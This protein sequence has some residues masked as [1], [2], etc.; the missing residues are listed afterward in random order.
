[1]AGPLDNVSDM[2]DLALQ[3]DVT[4]SAKRFIEAWKPARIIRDTGGARGNGG[5]PPSLPILPT[6]SSPQNSFF[7]F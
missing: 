2:D 6:P 1:M 3:F 4:E 7:A 5:T